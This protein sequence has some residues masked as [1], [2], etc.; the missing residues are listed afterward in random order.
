MGKEEKIE[1]NAP[2][3]NNGPLIPAFG[4]ELIREFLLDELLGKEGPQL[5]YWAGKQLGRRFP[6]STIDETI[7]FFREAGWGDLRIAKESKDEVKMELSGELIQRRYSI[8]EQANFQLEAG[9]L[10]FQFENMKKAVSE[11]YEEQKKRANI[12][13]FTIKTDS[14]DL[15]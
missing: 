7:A 2:S 11:A 15:L 9:F 3:I 4:Y 14:K 5:L 10:A 8:N 1:E 6:L 12:V 13:Y